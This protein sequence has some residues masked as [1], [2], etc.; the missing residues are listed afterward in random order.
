MAILLY[1]LT[2]ADGPSLSIAAGAVGREVR[3]MELRSLRLYLEEITD[4]DFS[5]AGTDSLRKATSQFNQV[6][7]QISAESTPMAFPFPTVVESRETA[8]RLIADRES[9]YHSALLRLA[10]NVQ[11]E[12]VATWEEGQ[13]ADTA[14]P[15]RGAEYLRRHQLDMNR[16]A[17]LDAKLRSVTADSVREWRK[18]QERKSHRW[19]ALVA[20]DQ[21]DRFLSAL[22]NAGP[23]EGVRLRL[24]GPWPPSEF[25]DFADGSG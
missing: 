4:S 15:V 3:P 16:V 19:F 24:S 1:C 5:L 20:R 6:L 9:S 7:R 21:Q 12:I 8:E 18:R 13:Q 2:L 25:F 23:S 14:A 11:Y 22:R 10:G 17:G